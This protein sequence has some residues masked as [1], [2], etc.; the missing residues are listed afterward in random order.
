MNDDTGSTLPARTRKPTDEAAQ[1]AR[2]QEPAVGV[3]ELRHLQ[4]AIANSEDDRPT[5]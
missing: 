1:A 3:D 4:A 5:D 2:R